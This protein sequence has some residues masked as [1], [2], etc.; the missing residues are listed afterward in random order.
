MSSGY[1]RLLKVIN[2][3]PVDVRKTDR[4]EIFKN[5]LY[6]NFVYFCDPYKAAETVI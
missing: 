6:Y 1:K 2:E 4:F 3:W 5:K